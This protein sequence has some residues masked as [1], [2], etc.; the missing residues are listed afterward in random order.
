M[1]VII[2]VVMYCM[3]GVCRVSPFMFSVT[4]AVIA[5]TSASKVSKYIVP[6]A[7]LAMCLRLYKNTI[8]LKACRHLP[9][10]VS[11]ERLLIFL[12]IKSGTSGIL[13]RFFSSPQ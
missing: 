13:Q 9:T 12:S 10:A 4:I 8:F 3:S 2:V 7:S 6:V 11:H 1:L 5:A